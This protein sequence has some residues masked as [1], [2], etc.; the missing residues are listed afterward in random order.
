MSQRIYLAQ[1]GLALEKNQDPDRPLST[2]GINQTKAVA[3]TLKNS[4]VTISCIFHSGKLRALQTAEIFA[5]ALDISSIST[6]TGLEP[7]AAVTIL[8]SHL[9]NNHALY[10][11]HLPH[12]ENFTA[13]L[14]AEKTNKPIVRFTNSAV[15]CLEKKQDFY[16]LQ[17]SLTPQLLDNLFLQA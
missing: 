14:M 7:N 5:E 6:I 11:G 8:G 2:S 16:Q 15:I 1:H 4:N 13:Y 17:W 9:E 3:Q 12:L 10:I